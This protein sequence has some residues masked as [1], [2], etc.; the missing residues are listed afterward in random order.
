MSRLSRKGENRVT[1]ARP[2]RLALLSGK[3]TR[4][5]SAL[6]KLFKKLPGRKTA[7]ARRG[8]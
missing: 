3:K 6:A 4:A 7:A 2:A 8:R 5:R 1:V